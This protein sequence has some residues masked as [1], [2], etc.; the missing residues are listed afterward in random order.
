MREELARLRDQLDDETGDMIPR[1]DTDWFDDAVAGGL[2]VEG[3][4]TL[5]YG[6]FLRAYDGD[7][8]LRAIGAEVAGDELKPTWDVVR[9]I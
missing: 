7:G 6:I 4:E 3:T 9:W 5:Y 8:N 1:A 2:N